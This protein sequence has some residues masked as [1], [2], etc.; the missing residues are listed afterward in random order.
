MVKPQRMV[1]K[2]LIEGHLFP[3]PSFAEIEKG[4]LL[5]KSKSR[6]IHQAAYTLLNGDCRDT[7][8]CPFKELRTLWGQFLMTLIPFTKESEANISCKYCKKSYEREA[9]P[10]LDPDMAEFAF[11]CSLI[12]AS[13]S[14][15]EADKYQLRVGFYHEYCEEKNRNRRNRGSS[16]SHRLSHLHCASEIHPQ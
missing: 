8:K 15:K 2:A 14:S 9:L 5:A 11:C 6:S 1:S 10:F 7:R 12:G 16:A 13:C 4:A 3:F